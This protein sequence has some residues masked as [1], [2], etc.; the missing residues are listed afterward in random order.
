MMALAAQAAQ[1]AQPGPLR[2]TALAE[3]NQVD[4]GTVS[5]FDGIPVPEGGCGAV[6]I[7]AVEQGISPSRIPLGTGRIGTVSGDADRIDQPVTQNDARVLAVNAKWSA[8]MAS[9]GYRY[10]SPFTA[11]EDRR[12]GPGLYDSLGVIS[13]ITG[14]EIQ[15]AVADVAC[16]AQVNLYAVYW[17]VAAAYQR[18]WM[19]SPRHMALAQAQR[20]AD[21][22]MLARADRILR[23]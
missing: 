3:A 1:A 23:S 7:A 20:N 2:G 10:K 12:W 18:E 8:C 6:G 16:R 5:S 9:S 17:A 14:A 19:A 11:L 22:V 4:A 15:V 21:Q 13:K